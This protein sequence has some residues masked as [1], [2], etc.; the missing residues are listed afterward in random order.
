[1]KCIR[2]KKDFTISIPLEMYP[3]GNHEIAS[4]RWCR[5]CN[6]LAVKVLHRHDSAY[7]DGLPLYDPIKEYPYINI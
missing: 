6:K 7:E 4:T 1:M 3:E 5:L 2:C